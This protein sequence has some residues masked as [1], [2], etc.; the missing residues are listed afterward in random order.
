MALV[1]P[2]HRLAVL[3]GGYDLRALANSAGACV[4]AMAGVSY[5]PEPATVGG[6]GAPSSSGWP[7]S[8]GS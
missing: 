2:G 8:A 6:P 5:R 1:P 4:A 3:E 7:S